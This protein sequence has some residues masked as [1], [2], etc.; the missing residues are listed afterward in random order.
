ML[1]DPSRTRTTS[2]LGGGAILA[3]HG[4]LTHG[5]ATPRTRSRMSPMRKSMRRT[6]SRKIF[7][8]VRSD[9]CRNCIAAQSST[10]NRRRFSRWT[11]GGIASA[12]RPARSA[13]ARKPIETRTPVGPKSGKP[14]TRGGRHHS[15]SPAS[16]GRGGKR[17]VLGEQVWDPILSLSY[18]SRR[19]LPADKPLSR[20][21]G[22]EGERTGPPYEVG[23]FASPPQSNL[24]LAE[25]QVD[26]QRPPHRLVRPHDMIIDA[27]LSRPVFQLL[28]ESLEVGQVIIPE[29]AR[30]HQDL[31][32]RGL[33]IAELRQPF[34][35][36]VKL[37][38][39]QDVEEHD[40]VVPVQQV[41]RGSPQGVG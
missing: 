13:G 40:L 15:L 1:K 39:G 5:D 28:A 7:L 26:A 23:N 37:L 16:A 12:T 18:G 22:G 41:L 6:C 32:G 9:V 17:G 8:R 24:A 30:V 35:R 31:V 21:S 34:V 11:I 25:R 20:P 2:R 19:S 3:S 10:S 29:P 14:C 36:E 33:Q 38:R 4:N 27:Q